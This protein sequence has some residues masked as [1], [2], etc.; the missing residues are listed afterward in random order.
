MVTVLSVSATCS[1]QHQQRS[2]PF[3]AD[4]AR[5]AGR[6]QAHREQEE[7]GG[8]GPAL[9]R[10]RQ[11]PARLIRALHP[12][13][14]R[15]RVHRHWHP[16]GGSSRFLVIFELDMWS[17]WRRRLCHDVFSGE[18]EAAD[19]GAADGGAAQRDTSDQN[20]CVFLS[21]WF[22]VRNAPKKKFRS[23]II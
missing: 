8:Q 11:L 16:P 10:L 19:G 22:H 9:L 13:E 18:A 12:A 7:E 3:D 5:C 17:S 2:R 20:L 23:V 21:L 15:H 14:Q 4:D 1:C 6:G